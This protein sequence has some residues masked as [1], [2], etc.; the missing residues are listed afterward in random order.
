MIFNIFISIRV[1]S[2]FF[3]FNLIP[4]TSSLQLGEALAQEVFIKRGQG[5]SWI[6][7]VLCPWAQWEQDMAWAAGAAALSLSLPFPSLFCPAGSDPPGMVICSWG[8]VRS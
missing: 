7:L 3:P 4:A 1:F 2:S 8:H 6:F 5:E